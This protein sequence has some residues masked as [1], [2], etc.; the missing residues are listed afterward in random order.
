MALRFALLKDLVTKDETSLR[1]CSE[2]EVFH[3]D[4][5]VEE[6]MVRYLRRP[7]V[8]RFSQEVLLPLCDIVMLV[9]DRF[10]NCGSCP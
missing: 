4:F 7:D 10:Q 9:H 2:F 3:L 8:A 1:S 5:N 6:D